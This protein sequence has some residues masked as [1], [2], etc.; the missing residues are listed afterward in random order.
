[1]KVNIKAQYIKGFENI[2]VFCPF[3]NKLL[4]IKIRWLEGK[5]R[6]LV[7]G[8][9]EEIRTFETVNKEGYIQCPFC[10]ADVIVK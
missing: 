1:M 7:E 9:E 5:A 3:C 4:G 2:P 8:T 10:G 6:I